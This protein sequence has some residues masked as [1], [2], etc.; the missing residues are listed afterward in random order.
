MPRKRARPNNV[1]DLS[2]ERI[3]AQ[4]AAI[5]LSAAQCAHFE[6]DCRLTGEGAAKY[7]A[8][9]REFY[10]TATVSR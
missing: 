8:D 5:H 4:Q 7:S 3:A 9:C 2:I 1:F 10:K 6:R